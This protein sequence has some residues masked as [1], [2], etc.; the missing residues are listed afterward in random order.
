MKEIICIVCPN[1][2]KLE[3]DDNM[4]V[5]GAKCKRGNEFAVTELTAPMRTVTST[6]KTSF[7]DMPVL[8]VKTDGEIPKDKMFAFMKDIA[9]ILVDKP[10]KMGEIVKTD[11]AGTGINV[12]AT[13]SIPS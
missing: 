5:T 6:V 11:V 2:C 1:S 3:I 7:K 10:L 8:P 12:I 13:A 4:N 9:S